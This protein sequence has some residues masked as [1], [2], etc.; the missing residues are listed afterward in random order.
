[1]VSLDTAWPDLGAIDHTVH[2]G[3]DP[4]SPTARAVPSV[5]VC[6]IRNESPYLTGPHT[7]HTNTS[8][9]ARRH[10][11]FRIDAVQHVI[12]IAVD[13]TQMPELLPLLQDGPFLVE[14]LYAAVGPVGYEE[15][16]LRVHGQAMGL[17]ELSRI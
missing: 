4:L 6:R 12:L 1:M 16:A 14:D 3:D 8:L 7:S 9:P 2:I 11:R 13:P 17:T 15:A 5:R 10:V